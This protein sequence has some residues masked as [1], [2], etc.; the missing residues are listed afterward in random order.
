MDIHSNEKLT[1]ELEDI[2][3]EEASLKHHISLL[4]EIYNV[5]GENW[6]AKATT[7]W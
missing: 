7:I 3:M 6:T 1:Q 5:E 2:Q 4:E